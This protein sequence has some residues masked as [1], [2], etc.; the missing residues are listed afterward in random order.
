M[1]KISHENRAVLAWPYFVLHKQ[2]RRHCEKS[3]SKS[4][5]TNNEKSETNMSKELQPSSVDLNR[6]A[7]KYDCYTSHPS[8]QIGLM[9]AVR[10]HYGALKFAEETSGLCCLN[11]KVKT[12][13]LPSPPEPLH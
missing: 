6:V 2:D 12:P 1:N 9:E 7:C 3:S 11:G 5:K 13:L 8:A 10:N 4:F